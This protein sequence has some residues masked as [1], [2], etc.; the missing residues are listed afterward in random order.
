MSRI[1]DALKKAEAEQSNHADDSSVRLATA[2]EIE[3]PSHAADSSAPSFAAPFTF[4]AL[5]ERCPVGQWSPD[6]TTMLFFGPNDY[7]AQETFRTLRS[8]L[9]QI[10]EKQ[11]LKKIMITSAMGNEGKSF[12]AANLAQVLVQQQGQKVLLIDADLRNPQLHVALGTSPAPGFTDY[13]MGKSEEFAVLQRGPME[14]LFFLPGGRVV[15]SPLELIA[16]G[17]LNT[18]LDRMEPIFDWIIIDSS[19]AVQ[20][21][22]AGQLATNCDGVL[23]VVRSDATPF[24]WA[25]RARDEFPRGKIIGVVLNAVDANALS[26]SD[27]SDFRER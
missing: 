7:E 17:R 25:Q 15:A 4:E 24:D 12:V 3:P 6:S 20:V 11:P 27:G 16:S 9:Y 5:L 23:M 18:L 26:S 8:R 14:G 13:L 19:P 21:S 22:D 1:H 2:R 10:R